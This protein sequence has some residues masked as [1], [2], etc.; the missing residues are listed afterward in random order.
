MVTLTFHLHSTA[1]EEYD[2]AV[3]QI[4]AD[5]GFIEQLRLYLKDGG[6]RS[7]TVAAQLTAELAKAG[8]QRA[9]CYRLSLATCDCTH[10][11]LTSPYALIIWPVVESNLSTATLFGTRSLFHIK[12]IAKT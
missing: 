3:T 4:L 2:A 5:E 8:R 9:L 6:T 7:A 1:T 10:N 12:A 11:V